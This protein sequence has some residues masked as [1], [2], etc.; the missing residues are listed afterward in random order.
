M[1]SLQLAGVAGLWAL[2]RYGSRLSGTTPGDVLR[3]ATLAVAAIGFIRILLVF[4]L[5][6]VLAR[7]SIPRVLSDVTFILIMI[8]YAIYRMN[9]IGVNPFGL[10]ATSALASGAFVFSL[11]EP[12]A[13][14]GA[15]LALQLD[16]TYRIGDWLLVEGV[17]AQVVGIRWRYTSLAT[18]AGE[19]IILPNAGLVRNRV[20]I[21][22]RRG[23]ERIT[24]RRPIEFGVG[25]EWAP[26][27]VIA[28]VEQGLKR[29][30]IHN[31]SAVPPVRCMCTSFGGSVINYTLYYWLTDLSRDL[32]TDSE[33]RVHIFAALQREG[34]EIP[35]PRNDVFI[36][37]ARDVRAKAEQRERDSRVALLASLELFAPLTDEERLALAAELKPA[38]FVAG[39]II[40][41]VGEH[42]DSL[43]ILADGKVGIF[44]EEEEHPSKGRQRLATLG[45]PSYFGEMGLLTGQAR[46]ATVVAEAES[47]CY[48]LD[49]PGFEAILRARPEL[50]EALSM[51]LASRQA[52]NDATLASLSAE[53]RARATG[54]R[55]GDLVRSI[56]K[57]FGL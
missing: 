42:A 14:L 1:L 57:F 47:V 21:L 17:S 10:A 40:T 11:R 2:D 16:N 54:T 49:K 55:A 9:A 39:D 27:R 33:I 23:E 45:G 4:V 48:K 52:A 32:P 38:P 29:A 30:E 6:G 26:S 36:H 3:E 41:R 50:T 5:Q 15:G 28:A 12:L 31:I 44:R 56:K 22:A 19:T 7:M 18:N 35:I 46:M 53:A 8:G 24:W 13:N 43:Y 51:T 34:I 25:Y 20:T 37:P